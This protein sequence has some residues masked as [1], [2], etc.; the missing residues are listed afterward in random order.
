[1]RSLR[2]LNTLKSL[3]TS[4]FAAV[5][6]CSSSTVDSCAYGSLQTT[7]TT[8]LPVLGFA[9]AAAT[10]SYATG[11]ENAPPGSNSRQTSGRSAST[12]LPSADQL[13]ESGDWMEQWAKALQKND[14]AGQAAVLEKTFGESP[15]PVG[16][17]LHELLSYNRK[18]EERAKRRMNELQKQEQIRQS[19]QGL[20]LSCCEIFAPLTHGLSACFCIVLLRR[21]RML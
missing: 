20:L 4:R 11:T 2:Q 5:G 7:L 15:D 9:V 12:S 13:V 18:E 3:L 16:P 21:T 17:P 14:V 1:M 8:G 10:R 6:A 19:R